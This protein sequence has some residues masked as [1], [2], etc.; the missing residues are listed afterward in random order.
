VKRIRMLWWER[1]QKLWLD[2]ALFHDLR[3]ERLQEGE[4]DGQSWAEGHSAAG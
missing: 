3:G 1:I 4:L 2:S